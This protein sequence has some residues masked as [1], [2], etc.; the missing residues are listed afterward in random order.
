MQSLKVGEGQ[1]QQ[2][3]ICAHW[4][5]FPPLGAGGMLRRCARV[6][7]WMRRLTDASVSGNV[8]AGFSRWL[9]ASAWG[10]LIAAG[11]LGGRKVQCWWTPMGSRHL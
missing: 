6:A 8:I 10:A 2:T 1:E 3:F 7:S 11:W 4:R 9:R 5:V